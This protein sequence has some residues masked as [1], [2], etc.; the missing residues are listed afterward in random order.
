[1]VLQHKMALLKKEIIG[2]GLGSLETENGKRLFF[3]Y[4]LEPSTQKFLIESFLDEEFLKSKMEKSKRQKERVRRKGAIKNLVSKYTSAWNSKEL[5]YLISERKEIKQ[6]RCKQ[7]NNFEEVYSLNGLKFFFDY[8]E[9][10]GVNLEENEND[11]LNKLFGY[12]AVRKFIFNK[13][14]NE[15]SVIN[16][17]FKFYIKYISINYLEKLRNESIGFRFDTYKSENE[18]VECNDSDVKNHTLK[19]VMKENLSLIEE[20]FK[21]YSGERNL[22]GVPKWILNSKKEYPEEKFLIDFYDAINL[23]KTKFKVTKKNTTNWA[24]EDPLDKKISKLFL[25]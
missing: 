13:Y 4:F 21:L 11:F 7:E 3:R 15:E 19:Q 5:Q 18:I 23:L 10:K 16:A 1:M 22:N 8:C 20:T 12:K 24:I 17:I 2:R 9:E 6:K 14:G 25:G